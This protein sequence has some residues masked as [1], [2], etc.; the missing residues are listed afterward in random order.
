[1]ARKSSGTTG[2]RAVTRADVARYAGVSD[3]VVSFVVNGGPKTVSEPT[4]VRVRDAIQQ[5]GYRPNS[6]ARA[7]ALGSTK[8][9]GLVVP[10][11]TNPFYAEYTLAIQRAAGKLGFALLTSSS[12]FDPAV[13]LR[14]MLELCDR[15]IDGLLLARGT[16]TSGASELAR[17]GVW[18]PIVL[19]D[20]ATAYP[21]YATIGPAAADGI[22]AVVDH[23]LRVHDHPSVSLIIGDTADVD[24]DGREA[25]WL[26]AHARNRR[27]P[28]A[29]ERTPFTRQGGYE[30]G[31]R[32]LQLPD[33]P[34]A[35]VTGSDLQ[36]VGLLRAVR[37]LGLQVPDDVAVA[38]FDGTEEARFSWPAL[39]TS[40][41]RTDAMAEAAVTAVLA[42]SR[43]P[44]GHQVFATDL[45]IGRSCG[46]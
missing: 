23:L 29:V 10:D 33:R 7:L 30:A 42:P 6:T 45:V 19:I 39:T 34:A 2:R 27:S 20:S 44:A 9:L 18:T 40:R 25:G 26:K 5:L 13:E 3:A 8:T 38:S 35:I 17:R 41:Q 37:E 1:V 36:A 14:A 43:T 32:L 21:G 16:G 22:D 11:S 4:A 15:Q 46:C 24:T 31:I 28:G 12:G